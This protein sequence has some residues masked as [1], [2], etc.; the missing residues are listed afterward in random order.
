MVYDD[1]RVWGSVD[2]STRDGTRWLVISEWSSDHPGVGHSRAALDWLRPQ[3]DVISANS[4]GMIDDGV[5]DPS[6]CYWAHMKSLGL[7][8][9]LIDDEGVELEVLPDESVRRFAVVWECERG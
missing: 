6:I 8:D 3:F 7:V 9:V 1:G 5:P 4:V 2:V